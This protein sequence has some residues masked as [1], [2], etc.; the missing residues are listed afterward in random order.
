VKRRD[1]PTDSA[2]PVDIVRDAPGRPLPPALWI[3]DVEGEARRAGWSGED[4][5]RSHGEHV[6]GEHP[7]EWYDLG[8]GGDIPLSWAPPVPWSC[9]RCGAHLATDSDYGTYST[10]WTRWGRRDLPSNPVHG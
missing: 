9:S 2:R 10:A 6:P 7:R 4:L 8:G 1:L 5:C 3:M